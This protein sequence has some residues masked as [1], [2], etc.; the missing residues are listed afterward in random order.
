MKFFI[1]I[2]F[3]IVSGALFFAFIDPTYS[4]IKKL[5][6]EKNLF[7]EALDNSKKLQQARDE[8]LSTYNSFSVSDLERL[9]KMLPNAVD[10]VRLVRDIDG[11]ASKYGMKIKNVSI[12]FVGNSGEQQIGADDEPVGMV[13]LSFTVTSPYR[14]FVNFLKDLEKSLRI[15]DVISVSFGAAEKDFYEYNVSVRT[16]WLK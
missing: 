3:L 5:Q 10:N 6:Q 9:D 7:D 11:I 15:I 8:L 13:D 12:S 16:Y 14:I 1:P 4:E 2:I